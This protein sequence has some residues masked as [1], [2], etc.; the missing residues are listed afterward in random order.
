MKIFDK[1]K[2]IT[3]YLVA[4]Y[5]LKS[6]TS[7]KD[8][9][10]NL[11]IGQSVGNPNVRNRWESDE[12]FDNHSAIVLHDEQELLN[13]KEGNVRIAFPD[14]N[15]DF[16]GDGVSQLLCILMGGQMDIDNIESCRLLDIELSEESKKYFLGPKYGITGIRKF[17]N[18]YDKPLFGAIVKPKTGITPATLLEMVKELV[19]GGANFIKED[20]ILSNP[21]FCKIEDRVPLIMNYINSQ[22]RPVIYSVCIN[23]DPAYI[24]DRVKLVHSLG[25]NSV[26]VNIWSGIGV[27]QSIRKLDLP[28]FIHYQKSGDK[29]I[30]DST[31]RFSISWDVM[32]KFAGLMGVDTIHSGM[33]GGYSTTDEDGIK[34]TLQVLR[35][36]NVFPALSCGMHPGLVQWINKQ[37]GIEYMA[38]VGGATHGHPG[39]T[40]AGAKAMVQAISGEHGE[41]YKQAIE[42]WG[43]VE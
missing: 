24:L 27:Y 36:H 19:E 37:V 5:Y 30:T 21:S 34:K 2:D 26:H 28:I 22:P 11:A 33:I 4:T 14:I 17:L 15:V 1:N 38:N 43:L 13:I 8:A 20:E 40:L 29:V 31:H 9:A 12:L 25:G 7:V 42:K 23:S 32:C 39:G 35:E 10:W 3:S 6:K 41:E 16:E 18:V